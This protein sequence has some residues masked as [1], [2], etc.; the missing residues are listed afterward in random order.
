MP[1]TP[2]GQPDLQGY[3]TN[4]NFTPL[5][6]PAKFAGK[7]FFAP[8]EAEA[9][10]KEAVE[11]SYEF[12]FAN[13]A[14]TPVYDAT[15]YGLDRWQIGARQNNRTSL[16]VDP[17]DGRV[18]ADRGSGEASGRSCGGAEWQGCL[19]RTGRPP[20]GYP[21]HGRYPAHAWG[22]L[23]QPVSHRAE[24]DSCDDCL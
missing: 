16:I 24:S 19:R 1:R 23:P 13:S 6:R 22:W 7:E 17:P 20:D 14:E 15:V 4:P 2:D 21:V 5:E 9:F 10:F 8:E 12:T 3:Y 18:P 11:R